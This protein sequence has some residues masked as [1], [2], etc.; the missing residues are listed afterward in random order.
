MDF[1][2]FQRDTHHWDIY[3]ITTIDG[4][5]YSKRK[6]KIRGEPGTIVLIRAED[7]FTLSFKTPIAAMSYVCDYL[8]GI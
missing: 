7:S 5:P 2:V 3:T 6:F 8:M 1:K 4:S